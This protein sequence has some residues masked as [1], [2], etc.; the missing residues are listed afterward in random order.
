MFDVI[1]PLYNNLHNTRH[2]LESLKN[3]LPQ[4]SKIIIIDDHSDD[5]VSKEIKAIC[6]EFSVDT[7]YILNDSVMGYVKSCNYGITQ[8]NNPYVVFVDPDTFLFNGTFEKIKETFDHNPDVGIINPISNHD[9]WTEIPF[10]NG[11]NMNDMND[12]FS[13]NIPS[14]SL[15]NIKTASKFF[16]AIKRELIEKYGLFD[17]IFSIRQYLVTD[18]SMRFLENNYRTVI[19]TSLYVFHQGT[20]CYSEESETEK[21][22]NSSEFESKWKKS[23]LSLKEEWQRN[24]P[25]V[26]LKN[27]LLNAEPLAQS[28]FKVIY[29]LKDLEIYGGVISVIQLVNQLNLLGIKTNIAA[30]GRVNEDFLREYPITF[31]PFIFQSEKELIARFPECDIAV[32][33]HWSTVNPLMEI[34]KDMDIKLVYFVQDFEPDFY[35]EDS[36]YYKKALATYDIIETKIVKSG[37]LKNLL[38]NFEGNVYHIP[39]GLDTDNFYDK[40]IERN[41]HVISHA[42]PSSER[43]N[44]PMLK[45]V[46][47][48]LKNEDENINLG[49][50]GTNYSPEDFEVEVKDFGVLNGS[51]E[52]AD[53]LNQS[54]ILLDVSTFQG[55]GRPGLEA[56]ACNTA[57]VLTRN[58]GITEYAKHKYNTLLVNPFDTDE[59]IRN[60]QTL[61]KNHQLRNKLT[62]NGLKTSKQYILMNE[63]L[64]TKKLFEELMKK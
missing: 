19:N 56:M 26:N 35:E 55:F 54:V 31:N 47:N 16:M 27:N 64:L 37:W 32:A 28:G 46:F 7:T 10:P 60:I 25:L 17:D 29:L 24:N 4:D 18:L 48:R 45:E 59:I 8:G 57:T 62:K 36:E 22:R 1:I 30:Y 51:M 5:F 38:K 49:V 21:E 43:R 41:I 23:Y 42:R 9:D 40:Q 13:N 33:T 6:K 2:C 61:L 15:L 52:V 34:N 12:F 11:F 20:E 39:L 58:G 44:F 50:Y 63:I 14:E 3:I 53:A